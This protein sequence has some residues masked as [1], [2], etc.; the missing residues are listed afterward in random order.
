MIPHPVYGDQFQHRAIHGAA[1]EGRPDV[2]WEVVDG[3]YA[4]GTSYQLQRPLISFADLAYG[5]MDSVQV[6]PR[7]GTPMIGLGHWKRYP[8]KQSSPEQTLTIPMEMVSRAA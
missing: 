4:D 8:L 6:S 7:V 5:Q 1:P 3:T 2:E